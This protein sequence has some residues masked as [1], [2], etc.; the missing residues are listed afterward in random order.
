MY[1]LLLRFYPFILFLL[2]YNLD[3]LE[4]ADFNPF[5]TKS[6]VSNGNLAPEQNTI[7]EIKSI[8]PEVDL[9]SDIKLSPEKNKYRND[10]S[11]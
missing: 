3:F 1:L 9:K 6:S 8:E 11:S 7:P 4:D 2:G 10:K 5:Q